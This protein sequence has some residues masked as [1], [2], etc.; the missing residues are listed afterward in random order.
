MNKTRLLTVIVVVIWGLIAVETRAALIT[1]VGE[2]NLGADP[3][4]R[5]A[6]VAKTMDT[7]GD[8]IYG[9]QGYLVVNGAHAD[10]AGTGLPVVLDPAYATLAVLL[11]ALYVGA[12][13]GGAPPGNPAFPLTNDPIPGSPFTNNN[14]YAGIVYAITDVET[15]VFSITMT[16]DASFR[17]GVLA[18]AHPD[19]LASSIRV[20]GSGGGNTLQS[21]SAVV[22]SNDYYFFDIHA[23][24]G[25]VVTVSAT[26][27]LS[28]EQY[29]VGL[30]GITLDA[31][32]VPEPGSMLLLGLGGLIAFRLRQGFGG[33]G[34]RT[35]R[36]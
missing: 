14:A 36:G 18:N 33:H 2:Q 9:S 35:R 7:D 12:E 22:A 13:I 23:A 25:E 10:G 28:G 21:T 6:A 19:G 4:W 32:A 15:A 27:T 11:P 20:S 3:G 17:L 1:Y 16:Q 31:A 30:S 34:R 5:D 8:S 29:V 26:G 24:N